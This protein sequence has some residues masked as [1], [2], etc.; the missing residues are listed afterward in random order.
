MLLPSR[1]EAWLSLFACARKGLKE[2][3]MPFA[4][5]QPFHIRLS[6]M[7]GSVPWSFND[8]KPDKLRDAVWREQ[9]ADSFFE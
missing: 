3:I 6:A 8:I 2:V 4:R 9:L 7:S 1:A 5:W